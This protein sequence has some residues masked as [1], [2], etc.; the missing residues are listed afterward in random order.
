MPA[1]GRDLEDA[2][3]AARMVATKAQQEFGDFASMHEAYG[4]LAEEVVEFLDAVR[5]RQSHPER[6]SRC[7]LEGV[8]IAAVALRNAAQAERVKR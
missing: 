3:I 7:Y 1:Q 8:D 6:S 5:M 4:V 2:I